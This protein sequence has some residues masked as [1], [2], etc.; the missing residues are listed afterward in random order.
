MAQDDRLVGGGRGHDGLQ[1]SGS[2]DPVTRQ[3][4]HPLADLG[5]GRGQGVEV[6]RLDPERA[7]S[8]GC[9]E[10]RGMGHAERDRHLSEYLT[11][12]ALPDHALLSVDELDRLDPTRDRAS[13]A[14]SPPS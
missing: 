2:A 10:R 12:E 9:P 5:R 13:S 8:L 6:V 7:R 1:P 14:G 4:V 3:L 11:R